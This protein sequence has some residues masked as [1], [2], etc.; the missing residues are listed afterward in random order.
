MNRNK[1]Y[2]H[3][4]SAIPSTA[5]AQKL[6]EDSADFLRRWDITDL[7]TNDRMSNFDYLMCLNQAAGRSFQD[8]TQY[9]VFPWLFNN[10]CNGDF[11]VR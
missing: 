4:L 9:P 10:Y 1:V 2:S 5:I 3:I 7:W 8:I 11:D 6:D